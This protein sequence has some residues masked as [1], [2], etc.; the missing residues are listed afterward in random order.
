MFGSIHLQ[1]PDQIFIPF[2]SV[3]IATLQISVL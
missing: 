2:V 3:R 1:E